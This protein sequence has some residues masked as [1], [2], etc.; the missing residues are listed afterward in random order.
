[1]NK[2]TPS[3]AILATGHEIV[4][5]DVLNTNAYRFAHDL[6]LN[7]LEVVTHL[8]CRDVEK[9]ILS[10]LTYLKHHQVIITI[11]GL[12]PTVDDL[13]RFAVAKYL[14]LDLYPHAKALAHIQQRVSTLKDNQYLE[15]LFPQQAQLIPNSFGTALG[16]F[17]HHPNQLVIM[18]PGPP[19]EC[20]PMWDN[21]V[22]PYL[23]QSYPH[24]MPWQRW[25]LFGVAEAGIAFEIE[26]ALQDLD[27]EI[28]YRLAIPYVELK[29]KSNQIKVVEAKLK[30]VIRP[31]LLT[32]SLQK[33]SEALLAYLEAHDDTK[34]SIADR[35]TLG[36]LESMLLTPQL[37]SRV[38]FDKRYP[39]HFEFEG[40]ADY[41]QQKPCQSHL[42]TAKFNN[43][44]E[45]YQTHLRQDY[46]R[47]LAAEWACG[48]I[49][50]ILNA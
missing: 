14:K 42:L 28:A 31:Y 26:T 32:N 38:S 39:L 37:F 3:I 2:T 35:M 9:E 16:A 4:E 1:M 30:P 19:R 22:L 7:G 10:A 44:Q 20:L 36:L 29:L 23:S 6:S 40:L 49:L 21:H 48:V 41:W 18:L 34:I 15:T 12:G 45:T 8:S 47:L 24:Q 50:K 46:V 25:L 5:G 43:T 17:I 27:Y 13:T 33:A 11:G